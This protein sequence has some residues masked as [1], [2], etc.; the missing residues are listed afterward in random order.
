MNKKQLQLKAKAR[1][2]AK[3]KQDFSDAPWSD[4]GSAAIKNFPDSAMQMGKD[5]YQAVSHPIETGKAIADVASGGLQKMAGVDGPYVPAWDNVANFFKTRYGTIAG[6]KNALAKD[7]A[8]V[9][10]DFSAVLSLGGSTAARAPGIAGKVGK[11]VQKAGAAIDPLSMAGQ[12]VKGTAKAGGFVGK[13]TFGP[14]MT[15][16]AADDISRAYQ[17][18]IAGG[19]RGSLFRHNVRNLVNPEMVAETARQA[20]QKMRNTKSREYRV[21]S[22][23]WKASKQKIDMRPVIDDFHELME[24]MQVKGKT[25]HWAVGEESIRTLKKVGE[26]VD[27]FFQDQSVWT[28]EGLDALKKRLDDMMPNKLEMG[29]SEAIITR[30]R[31]RVKDLIVEKVPSYKKVMQNYEDAMN[32]ETE[33]K[34][35]LSLG[36]N[37]SVDTALRKLQSLTRNNANTN[38]GHRLNLVDKMEQS[39]G[40]NLKDPLAGQA[41]NSWTPRGINKIA[42]PAMVGSGAA[43]TNPAALAAL[44][45]MSPRLIGETAHAAGRGRALAERLMDR[46]MINATSTRNIGR[47]A[48]QAGRIDN[49]KDGRNQ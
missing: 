5:M 44:P 12:V 47:G 3:K 25:T 29:R 24:E 8:A 40:V 19:E 17:T 30:M 16:V 2:R 13:H 18:G 15:G 14:M 39:A 38:Y 26:T 42:G 9:M 31:N 41:M 1:L 43:F 36:N 27:E 46:A 32:L 22:K 33:I 34:K 4:V 49:E 28:A 37:A 35:G 11:I 23:A 45:L 7:S 48:F 20:L 10:A 6:F 21:G